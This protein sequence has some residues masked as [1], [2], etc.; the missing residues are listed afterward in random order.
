MGSLLIA[1]HKIK[2]KI[3]ALQPGIEHLKHQILFLVIEPVWMVK[4]QD[5]HAWI[6]S[7]CRGKCLDLAKDLT[8]GCGKGQLAGVSI[9]S[10]GASA[11]TRWRSAVS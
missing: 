11:C 6:L 1:V 4:G 10:Q 9:P 7:G 2:T 5:R 8:K 3:T